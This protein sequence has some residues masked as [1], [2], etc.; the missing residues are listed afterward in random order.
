MSSRRVVSAK[1]G[2][3][4]REIMDDGV[5]ALNKASA[6]G[7]I[8]STTLAESSRPRH[9]GVRKI[10][11]VAMAA[12]DADASSQWFEEVLGLQRIHDEV[13]RD[14][15]VRL[16]WLAPTDATAG[17]GQAS[18][19]IVQPLGPGA[20]A[21]FLAQKGEGLHHVCFAVDNAEDFLRSRGQVG[22]IFTGGYGLPCAFLKAV[23]EGIAVEIV[24]QEHPA[25]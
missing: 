21:D 18:F 12:H 9:D 13:V 25:S 4:E 2:S 3:V 10:D 1:G 20:I 11:H 19:Q 22:G 15:G 23:P 16:L 7:G 24:Q 5:D 6:I 8:D 14:V 17:A